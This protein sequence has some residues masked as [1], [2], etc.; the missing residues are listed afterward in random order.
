MVSI[1]LTFL[2]VVMFL[3]H[4]GSVWADSP[5]EASGSTDLQSETQCRLDELA[6]EGID[7]E[8]PV[9][10]ATVKV[11]CQFRI[12]CPAE[13]R[14]CNAGPTF[15]CC[16]LPAT[17]DPNMNADDWTGCHGAQGVNPLP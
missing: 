13:H 7:W 3:L 8:K 17:C 5:A 12:F 16:P 4:A 14:C 11:Y 9:T 6:N 15:W 2:T 1:A 10:V